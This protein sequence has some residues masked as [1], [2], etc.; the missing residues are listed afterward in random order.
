[1]GV[2]GKSAGQSISEQCRCTGCKFK[3]G[4]LKP[5]PCHLLAV[6]LG[7]TLHICGPVSSSIT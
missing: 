5:Q 1:M 3:Q 6:T 2:V 4:G 7:K